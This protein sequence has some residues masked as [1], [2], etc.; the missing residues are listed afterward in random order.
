M[1]HADWKEHAR[2]SKG[3]GRRRAKNKAEPDQRLARLFC[4]IGSPAPRDF[5][6]DPFQTEAVEAVAESD[7]LVTAPTGSGKTYIAVKAMERVLEAGGRCWYASP[8]KALSN[9]KFIEFSAHFGS[10]D[11]GILTGDRRENTQA[12]LIVGTTEILRNQLY[13]CMHRGCDIGAD[14]VVLDEAHYLGDADRGVVWEETIIY[15]P[16]RVP[17]LLLSATIGNAEAIA[18]WISRIRERPCR[19]VRE[20]ARP[21][22]LAHLF[23]HPSGALLPLVETQKKGGK[24]RTVLDH[25]LYA[26]LKSR[27]PGKKR[28]YGK[29]PHISEIMEV[30]HK[31]NLLPAIFFL[32]SRRDC[33]VAATRLARPVTDDRARTRER[34]AYVDVTVAAHPY[35]EDHPQ[36][37]SLRRAAVAAHHAG[38]LPAWKLL[39]EQLL[40][41][42]LVDAVFA[43]STVAAGVNFPARTVVILDS[44]RFNGSD[45]AP[46]TATEFLQMTGRA[47]RRGMDRIGFLLAVAGPFLDVEHVAR[48]VAEPPG[49]VLSR[50]RIDFSMCLNL[51]MSHTVADIEVVLERSFARFLAE[52]AREGGKRRSVSLWPDFLRHL[53]FLKELSYVTEDDRLTEE[54]AWASALRADHPLLLAECIRRQVLPAND[55]RLLAALVAVFVPD[56]DQEAPINRRALG[57]RLIPAYDRLSAAV[58]PLCRKMASRGFSPRTPLLWPAATIYAWAGNA[59]WEEARSITEMADG[60][61]ASL[62][63]RTADNLRQI[64]DLTDSFPELAK[65]ARRAIGRIL[66][67]PVSPTELYLGEE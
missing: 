55:S 40:S 17:L 67:G 56:R 9:S 26:M 25:R 21:V 12:R 3:K 6:P 46:L 18:E 66:R 64:T 32:K 49:P 28:F 59:E 16:S 2:R 63:L 34:N 43:T 13:D 39:V 15:L 62:I 7:C 19:V 51:L 30:L 22:P 10:R 38:Q 33:D 54:G 41:R 45:F 1:S 57:P 52:R 58:L 5:V 8:L 35:L 31:N 53:N 50:I 4:R 61:L 23:L 20:T 60:D 47:G 11:V 37:P 14:L 48:L 27:K 24:K 29:P 36:L 65:A 44:D 42:G